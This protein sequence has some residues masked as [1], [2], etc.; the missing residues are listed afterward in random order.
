MGSSGDAI[1]EP[2]SCGG[3]ISKPNSSTSGLGGGRST[4]ASKSCAGK[5]RISLTNCQSLA[6]KYTYLLPQFLSCVVSL[7]MLRCQEMGTFL[8]H[9]TFLFNQYSRSVNDHYQ[10]LKYLQSRKRTNRSAGGSAFES[11]YSSSAG[12][13]SPSSS[14]SNSVIKKLGLRICSCISGSGSALAFPLSTLGERASSCGMISLGL[15]CC[16]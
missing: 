3:S 1:G 11:S 5:F 9:F 14:S 12:D 2:G 8:E 4:M 15:L 10:Q 13:L 16:A 7:K 6:Q